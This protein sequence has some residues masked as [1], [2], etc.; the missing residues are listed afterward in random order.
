MWAVVVSLGFC[1]FHRHFN[2][3][4]RLG[5][6]NQPS[7]L[8]R[9]ENGLFR[10]PKHTIQTRQHWKETHIAAT[11]RSETGQKISLC[12]HMSSPLAWYRLGF[13]SPVRNWK[14][15]LAS[16]RKSAKNSRKVGKWPQNPTVDL[17]FQ[18]FWRFSCGG[19][20]PIFS[21]ARNLFCT[22]PYSPIRCLAKITFLYPPEFQTLTVWHS[23]IIPWELLKKNW[24]ILRPPNVQERKI[25]S[26]NHVEIRNFCSVSELF[27]RI[28]IILCQ[29]VT[30]YTA[31]TLRHRHDTVLLSEQGCRERL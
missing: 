15:N 5:T 21:C 17:L 3:F 23:E 26:P 13:R 1:L 22:R 10:L 7:V 30:C 24:G 16:P 11:P 18:F 19:K 29:R 28:H 2:W 20:K 8:W 12:A 6:P 31:F 4:W 14:R 25:L 9:P 27:L